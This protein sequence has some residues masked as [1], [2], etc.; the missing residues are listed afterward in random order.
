MK[1]SE[2]I[3]ILDK[4]RI[5]EDDPEIAVYSIQLRCKTNNDRMFF[6]QINAIASTLSHAVEKI[7]GLVLAN[8][9]K[10]TRAQAHYFD[11]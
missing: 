7:S 1:A 11:V 9:K 4:I 6:V 5:E 3:A 8:E 10:M 2:A